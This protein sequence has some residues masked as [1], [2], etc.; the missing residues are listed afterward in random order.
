M[1]TDPVV[2]PRVR[3]TSTTTGTGNIALAGAMRGSLTFAEAMAVGDTM[4]I[5]ISYDNTFEECAA[6]LLSGGVT[7]SRGT[8]YRSRH[9]NG[10]V[11]QNHV[12]FA[13]GVKTVVGVFGSGRLKNFFNGAV[14]FDQ[15]QSL[16]TGQ[17]RQALDNM[18]LFPTGTEMMFHQTSAPTGWTKQTTHNDKALRVVSGSVSSGGSSAF[19]TVFGLTATDGHAITQAE[20]PNV[21]FNVNIPSGQGSHNHTGTVSLAGV[22]QGTAGGGNLLVSTSNSNL[23]IAANTLP[24]MTGTAASG[25]SGSSHSH[26]IDL[27]VQYVD[28][29]IASK[30]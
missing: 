17:K 28:V 3:E 14:R 5:C 19:S 7:L 23:S 29:I 25:G 20:L 9:A 24:A 16:T 30:D 13:A 18:G 6:T 12:S 15:A 1:A 4:D 11:D 26:A 10:T 27:R 2:E 8:V 21:S 22:Q